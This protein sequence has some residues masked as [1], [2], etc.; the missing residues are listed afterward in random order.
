MEAT[1][2]PPMQ[3]QPGEAKGVFAKRVQQAIAEE[4]GQVVSEC[5]ITVKKRVMQQQ[6]A[7]LRKRK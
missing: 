7:K 5:N 4:L 1:V 3:L 2:L 6:Q